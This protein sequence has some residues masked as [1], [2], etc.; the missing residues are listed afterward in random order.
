[1]LR[2]LPIHAAC[3]FAGGMGVFFAMSAKSYPQA[4]GVIPAALAFLAVGLLGTAVISVLGL[5][6]RRIREL[7]QRLQD[8]EG[9]ER[10]QTCPSGSSVGSD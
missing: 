2:M 3:V 7:E 6:D 4:S 5:Q 8:R 10:E 9:Q 1:M